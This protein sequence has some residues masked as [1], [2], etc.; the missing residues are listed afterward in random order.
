MAPKS[1]N[2][3]K[4]G[5]RLNF[6]TDQ[7]NVATSASGQNSI[8]SLNEPLLIGIFLEMY[9]CMFIQYSRPF[10]LRI[11]YTQS[12]AWFTSL[13]EGLVASR[14]AGLLLSCQNITSDGFSCT[15]II[16]SLPLVCPEQELIY[17]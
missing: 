9:S 1:S 14:K 11:A 12:M 16:P 5:T 3:D 6:A 15:G 10:S 8:G 4:V 2:G 7:A 17:R 13:T